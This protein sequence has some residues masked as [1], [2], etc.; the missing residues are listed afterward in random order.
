MFF[1][2]DVIL[3]QNIFY[4]FQYFITTCLYMAQKVVRLC[5]TMHVHAYVRLK[6]RPRDSA[7]SSYQGSGKTLETNLSREEFDALKIL[8]KNKD[9]KVDKGNTVSILNRKD[10]FC[11]M[12]NI[13]NDKSKF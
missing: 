10:Y 2:T 13:L 7:F 1:K 12:E 4:Q 5:N 11:K 6:S 8:Y 9:K 3:L